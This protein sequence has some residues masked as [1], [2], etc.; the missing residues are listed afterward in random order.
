MT[1][2]ALGERIGITRQQVAAYEA[3]KAN[4]TIPFKS[5]MSMSEIF[6]ISLDVLVNSDLENG[7]GDLNV[8]H[9]GDLSV[10][11]DEKST[12]SEKNVR[13]DSREQ[14]EPVEVVTVNQYGEPNII[15]LDVHA[16]AGWPAN[17]ENKSFYENLPS[18]TLPGKEWRNNSFIFIE[19]KGD[20]MHPTIYNGD[21]I[22]AKKIN[23]FGHIR[24]GYVH[25]VLT[26]EGINCKRVL[27]RVDKRGSLVLKSDNSEYPTYQEPVVNI[28]SL[29]E[30]V[31]KMS[32]NFVN[33]G[34]TMQQ[35]MNSLTARMSDIEA[36][37]NRLKP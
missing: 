24:E 34:E 8:T 33:H 13:F 21:W 32:Y 20:S 1:Q 3:G 19:I 9:G 5:I 11:N 6:N 4:T 17:V 30:A 29:Y 26:N 12:F 14:K 15:Q 10:K 25:I 7:G 16:Q 18:F 28:L 2:S 37:L 35:Q 22:I 23:D 27:N 31:C 36:T